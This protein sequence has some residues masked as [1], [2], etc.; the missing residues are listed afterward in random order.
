MG[1]RCLPTAGS[2]ERVQGWKSQAKGMIKLELLNWKQHGHGFELQVEEE[3]L[4]QGPWGAA[5]N[6]GSLTCLESK[7]RVNKRQRGGWPPEI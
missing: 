3:T 2:K 4:L 7:H 5:A 1:S 6:E